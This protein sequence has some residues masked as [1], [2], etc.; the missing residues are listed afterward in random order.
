MGAIKIKAINME[1]R[2]I[3]KKLELVKKMK[4]LAK[5]PAFLSLKDH[6]LNFQ[7]FQH[8]RLIS[9]SKSDIGKIS[10]SLLDRIN[11]NLRNKLQFNQKKILDNVI[12][13]F[14]EIKNRNKY[15]FRKTDTTEFYPSFSEPIL[16]S[17]IRFTEAHVEIIDEEKRK[18]YHCRKF[19]LF[20]KNKILGRKKILTVVLK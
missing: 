13:W 20:Y 18:I 5:N 1:A 11:G 3:S 8:C 12:D 19:L 17:L 14:K 9:P 6:K 10:K 7:L 4:C 2:H 15:V 16:R